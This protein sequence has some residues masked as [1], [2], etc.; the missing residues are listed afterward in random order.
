MIS[1][2]ERTV[3]DGRYEV[4]KPLGRGG[5]GKVF[6]ARDLETGEQV[7]LKLLRSRFQGNERAIARFEREVEA[8]RR[9]DHPCIVKIFHAGRDGET[10]YYTMEY[11]EGKSLRHWMAQK[12]K[13]PFGSVVRVLCLVADALEHAHRVTIHRDVSPE[14]VMVMKDGGVRLLDFGMAKL[15]DTNQALTQVGVSL[16]KLLY[17]APE[18]R[19]NAAQVDRRAD[20]Y[21]LGVMF[22]ETLAGQLPDGTKRLTELRPD[23]PPQA[24]AFLAS[25]MADDPNERFNT[26]REFRAALLKL[27][28]DYET[29]A[30]IVPETVPS[31]AHSGSWFSRLLSALAFWRRP[32]DYRSNEI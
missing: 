23:L 16:G 12:G 5:V 24:E 20:I 19:M 31:S 26:A 29:G 15:T 11:I 6:L 14:N 30:A 2:E 18:Q 13:L 27:Y 21:P 32:Q 17:V 22:Y 3:I 25:A 7:A 8:V 9:L 28:T 1:P 10:V 4:L